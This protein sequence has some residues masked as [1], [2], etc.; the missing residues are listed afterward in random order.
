MLA[1]QENQLG[2]SDSPESL[3]D[4]D[5]LSTSFGEAADASA[6]QSPAEAA[7]S[8]SSAAQAMADMANAAAKNL[9][10]S[11]A[12]GLPGQSPGQQPQNTPGQG[13]QAGKPPSAGDG[14]KTPL[15]SGDLGSDVK[16][17]KVPDWLADLGVSSSDWIRMRALGANE[18]EGAVLVD[19]PE[20]YHDLVNRY[21]REVARESARKKGE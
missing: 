3:L 8:A 14:S 12:P 10:M 13:T 9:G 6:T 16:I 4:K 15:E 18:V 17:V 20:E 2:K 7:E 11:S 21:F 19:T 5:Q 1:A